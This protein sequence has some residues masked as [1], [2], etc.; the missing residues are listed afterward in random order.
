MI[1]FSPCLKLPADTPIRDCIRKMN[2]ASVGSILLVGERAEERGLLVGIF[3][4]RDVLRNFELL[5]QEGILEKNVRAI[6][7]RKVQT[8]CISELAGAAE[9]MLKGGFRHLP[10]VV[11][12]E[13]EE[14]RQLLGVVSIRDVLKWEVEKSRGG[15][16][17]L[18]GAESPEFQILLES[19]DQSLRLLFSKLIPALES[20]GWKFR[21]RSK[22]QGVLVDPE[23]RVLD[24]DQK[25]PEV[26]TQEV[27]E[28]SRNPKQKLILTY[29]PA[30]Y[31]SRVRGILEKLE[32]AGPNLTVFSK[33]VDI[34]LLSGA[35]TSAGRS[36]HK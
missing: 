35:L 25:S 28:H 26:W 14:A 22:E 10:I 32:K 12:K 20:A 18:G 15:D 5:A 24:L 19:A 34:L 8:L 33:P 9:K 36:A 16:Q 1:H 3:T 31:D 30:R 4:E 7:T 6:M 21:V 17:S 11:G 2:D 13:G 29:D 27:R 23:I